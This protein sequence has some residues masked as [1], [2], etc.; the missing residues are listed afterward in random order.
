MNHPSQTLRTFIHSGLEEK[1]QSMVEIRE[2]VDEE[3]RFT[4]W[5]GPALGIEGFESFPSILEII[6]IYN[7]IFVD[8]GDVI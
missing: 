4:T 3:R 7:I 1:G 6:I 2:D 5:R 8:T